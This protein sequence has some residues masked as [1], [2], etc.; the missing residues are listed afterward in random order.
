MHRS[1]EYEG[2]SFRYF[3]NTHYGQFILFRNQN[4]SNF[5]GLAIF[6]SALLLKYGFTYQNSVPT[7]ILKYTYIIF[8]CGGGLEC[9]HRSPVSNRKRRKGKPMPGGITGPPYH[10]GTYKYR[11]SGGDVKLADLLCKK[12]AVEESKE[13]NTE[14]PN[15]SSQEWQNLKNFARMA[16][17]RKE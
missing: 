8:P 13:V 15:S 6:C 4:S 17:A 9:I 16:M 2:Y 5:D 12:I 10:W 1:L 7:I 14:L 11:G 3:T